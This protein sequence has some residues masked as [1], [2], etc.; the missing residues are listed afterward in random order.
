M[1]FSIW[2]YGSSYWCYCSTLV[3]TQLVC[4][5]LDDA[6][7]LKIIGSNIAMSIFVLQLAFITQLS[8]VL[9]KCQFCI[10]Y[11]SAIVL[12]LMTKLSNNYRIENISTLSREPSLVNRAI[13]EN[14]TRKTKR[15]PS[16]ASLNILKRSIS[17]H[18][19]RQAQPSL[20]FTW[21]SH[22]LRFC[23]LPSS[24]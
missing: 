14:P 18:T 24:L 7:I 2:C 13:K 10:S 21:I 6:A 11:Q 1:N 20:C 16:G 12:Q 3:K 22:A 9:R 23:L 17:F 4:W 15:K 19:Q 5:L 8:A